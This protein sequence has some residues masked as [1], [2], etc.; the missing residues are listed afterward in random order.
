MYCKQNKKEPSII[1]INDNLQKLQLL[2]VPN[3]KQRHLL[4]TGMNGMRK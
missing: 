2:K 1:T 3:V 4:L